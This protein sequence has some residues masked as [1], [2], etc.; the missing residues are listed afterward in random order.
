MRVAGQG[1]IRAVSLATGFARSTIT[2]CATN[3]ERGRWSEVGGPHVIQ[4]IG[5]ELTDP[6]TAQSSREVV[7]FRQR[8]QRLTGDEFLS[9]PRFERDDIGTILGHGRYSAEARQ[10]AQI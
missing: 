9:H 5:L 6:D 7:A 1:G 4:G 2:C 8:V 3:G 10:R